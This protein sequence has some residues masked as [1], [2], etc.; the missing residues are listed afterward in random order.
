MAERRSRSVR[1]GWIRRMSRHDRARRQASRRGDS[2]GKISDLSSG[3]RRQQLRCR[4]P[5]KGSG[6]FDWMPDGKSVL[7]ARS[8]TAERDL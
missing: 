5:R 3:R 6:R 4:E 7:V 1:K 2:E 8:R